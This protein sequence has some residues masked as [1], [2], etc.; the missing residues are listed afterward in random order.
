MEAGP[1]SPGKTPI[2]PMPPP[3]P[4]LR[5]L[6]NYVGSWQQWA[7]REGGPDELASCGALKHALYVSP[8]RHT[9]RG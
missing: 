9:D 7:D 8:D 1:Q 6:Y 2:L 4:P 3:H 5:S